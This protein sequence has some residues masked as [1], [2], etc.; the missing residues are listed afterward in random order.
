MLEQPL[1]EKANPA[2]TSG[3]EAFVLRVFRFWKDCRRTRRQTLPALHQRLA[4]IDAAML[5]VPLDDF[6]TLCAIRR[7]GGS[8]QDER[9]PVRDDADVL[10]LL[11]AADERWMR[12]QDRSAVW[13]P[14]S[15]LLL[16]AWSVRRQIVGELGLRFGS[17]GRF[18][19][20]R[21][22]AY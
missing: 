3:A 7:T 16:S 2:R 8:G 17:V 13:T 22:T 21:D 19:S 5:A 1:H 12:L 15:L 11:H 9:G 14:G 10:A 20:C 18:R 4:S 6:F